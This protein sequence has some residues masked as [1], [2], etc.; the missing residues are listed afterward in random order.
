MGLSLIGG[1]TRLEITKRGHR[2]DGEAAQRSGLTCWGEGCGRVPLRLTQ[3]LC[4]DEVNSGVIMR[5]TPYSPLHWEAVCVMVKI[6]AL[7]SGCLVLAG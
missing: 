7:E 6:T 4:P 5:N 2:Y 3:A 1:Q